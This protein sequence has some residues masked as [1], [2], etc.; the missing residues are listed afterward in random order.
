VPGYTL[1]DGVTLKNK[2]GATGPDELERLEAGY[3][4]ARYNE[5]DAGAGPSGQFDAEHIKAIHQHLF[6]DVYE[7]A[8]R[9][10]D[11][12]VA[13]SDGSVATEPILSKVDGQPF[14]IGPAIPTALDDIGA[15]LRDADYLRG[16]HREQFAER[17]ADVLA[18]LNAAHP[19]REGNGR[20]QRVFL[21]QLA[22][23]AAHQLDFTVISKERMIQ[24]SIA[25]HERG[26]PSMMRRMFDEIGDPARSAML[27]ESIAALEKLNFDWNSHYVATLAPGHTVELV[28]AGV[29]GDQ[30]MARSRTEILFGRTA[31]LPEPRPEHGETFTVTAPPNAQNNDRGKGRKG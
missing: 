13:L 28:F 20:T 1:L 11:E 29:A 24:A 4:A 17:A 2:L 27:R 16:L 12:R 26:D 9:T 3:V 10:R 15:K 6:Q 22:H 25:A 18:E 31:D 30:F 14:L 19:F 7:W 21:E 23:T 5:I 8:G